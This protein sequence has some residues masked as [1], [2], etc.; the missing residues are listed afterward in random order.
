MSQMGQLKVFELGDCSSTV[1][2]VDFDILMGAW[3]RSDIAYN[4]LLATLLILSWDENSIR[5]R[6]HL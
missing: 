6:I 3:R 1:V 2:T 4:L 5:I